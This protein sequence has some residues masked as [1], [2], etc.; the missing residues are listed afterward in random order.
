MTWGFYGRRSELNAL[1]DVM[2]R[3]RFFFLRLTGG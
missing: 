3:E 2:V 1:R